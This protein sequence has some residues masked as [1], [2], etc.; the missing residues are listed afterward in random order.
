MDIL[1]IKS[2]LAS[3]LTE[4]GI[5]Y[6]SIIGTRETIVSMIEY[7]M[8]LTYNFTGSQEK[9]MKFL[10]ENSAE[11]IKFMNEKNKEETND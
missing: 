9:T 5:E 7:I 2:Q 3:K 6:S 1:Q 10:I 4:V 11:I 8:V